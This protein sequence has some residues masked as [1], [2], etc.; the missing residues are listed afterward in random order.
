[1]GSEKRAFEGSAV[2]LFGSTFKSLNCSKDS[3]DSTD[4]IKSAFL[5]CAFLLASGPLKAP[6]E[7]VQR[8][9]PT[10]PLRQ[11]WPPAI[12]QPRTSSSPPPLTSGEQIH[13]ACCKLGEI[14]LFYIYEF[15]IIGS[16]G[17]G[18]AC[19]RAKR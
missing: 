6:A 12:R 7:E 19:Q 10:A 9:S 11:V 18:A 4:S 17:R 1:M 16:N 8:S 14:P 5:S 3:M 15:P 2:R 13:H